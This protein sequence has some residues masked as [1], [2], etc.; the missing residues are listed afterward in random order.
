[1]Q[2]NCVSC[3]NL[4]STS[5]K[6]CPKCGHPNPTES[7]KTLT[8]QVKNKSTQLS[9]ITYAGFRKRFFAFLIDFF[10]TWVI[11]IIIGV[12]ILACL[13]FSPLQMYIR[14]D[15]DGSITLISVISIVLVQWLYFSIMESSS[16]QATLGKNALGIKVT[17]LQGNKISFLKAFTRTFI[18]LITILPGPMFPFT[19]IT[20]IVYFSVALTEK[21]QGLHDKMTECVIID[22]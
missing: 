16:S 4:C 7:L 8:E 12:I 11:S 1:M 5:A 15:F 10:I 9:T 13:Y 21:K 20:I 17:D 2:N 14:D 3:G 22:K 18:K 19:I 6:F